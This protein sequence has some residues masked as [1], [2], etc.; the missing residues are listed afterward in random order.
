MCWFVDF[1]DDGK[2]VLLDGEVVFW[3]CLCLVGFVFGMDDGWQMVWFLFECDFLLNVF[4]YDFLYVMFFDGCN[5]FY[6]VFYEFSYVDGYVIWWL[7]ECIELDDF[8]DD[9][10]FFMGEYI[11]WEWIEIVLVFCFWCDVI[12]VLVEFVWLWIYDV[13]VIVVLEVIG[14]VVVYVDDVYV[15]VDFFFEIVWLL[16]GVKLW[17]MSEYE[18]NGLCIGFVLF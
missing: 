13:D 9:L 8:C 18:Y 2:I 6:F 1:V 15:F 3:L 7:V 10:M 16:L 4:C 17:V 5:L 11:W 12:F 14:V